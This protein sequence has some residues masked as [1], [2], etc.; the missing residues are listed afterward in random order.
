MIPIANLPVQYIKPRTAPRRVEP[1]SPTAGT[2]NSTKR[3][4]GR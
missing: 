1:V 4:D 3:S 2:P